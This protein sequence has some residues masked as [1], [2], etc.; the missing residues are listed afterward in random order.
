MKIIDLS[1]T[2][3]YDLF[4]AG[5]ESKTWILVDEIKLKK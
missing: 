4:W 3:H 1:W 2:I 5:F